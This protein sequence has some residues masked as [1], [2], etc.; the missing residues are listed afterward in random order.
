M[1]KLSEKVSA[2]YEQ[3][4]GNEDLANKRTGT[5]GSALWG[6]V[7][8]LVI[9][10]NPFGIMFMLLGVLVITLGVKIIIRLDRFK[11]FLNYQLLDDLDVEKFEKKVENRAE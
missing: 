11:N 6:L 9:G 5:I 4:Q 7:T 1:H 10:F 3:E 2:Y 8:F